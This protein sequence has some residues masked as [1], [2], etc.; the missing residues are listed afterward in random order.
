MRVLWPLVGFVH[1]HADHRTAV[2]ISPTHMGRHL[3]ATLDALVG[4]NPLVGDRAD[5]GD[6]AQNTSN[7]RDLPLLTNWYG[8]LVSVERVAVAL[9]QSNM[10]VCMS[11]SGALASGLGMKEAKIHLNERHLLDYGAEGHNTVCGRKSISYSEGQSRSGQ[12]PPRD[13]RIPLR[14]S[15]VPA[16]SYCRATEIAAR[17]ARDMSTKNPAWSTDIGG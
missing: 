16:I 7:E 6:V 17:T 13:A 14:C 8:K 3:D 5:L 10:C 9:D 2:V 1:R 11:E 12:G 15:S 4:I